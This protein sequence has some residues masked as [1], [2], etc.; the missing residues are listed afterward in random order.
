MGL[1][2][3]WRLL[4]DPAL[5]WSVQSSASVFNCRGDKCGDEMQHFFPTFSSSNLLSPVEICV[6]T[7]KQVNYSIQ[8][9]HWKVSTRPF[10]LVPFQC[11]H[12][13][14]P[15]GSHREPLFVA[16]TSISYFK[17]SE[18]NVIRILSLFSHWQQLP[19]CHL[20]PNLIADSIMSADTLSRTN[21][22]E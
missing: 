3:A 7:S 12:K 1:S 9:T 5:C 22:H 4:L 18:F 17:R 20:H 11:P 21:V 8:I 15:S 10:K 2:G 6:T 13:V 16:M 14:M 19:H